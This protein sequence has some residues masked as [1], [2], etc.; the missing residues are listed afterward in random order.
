MQSNLPYI[1]LFNK[2]RPKSFSSIIGQSI[3]IHIIS[4]AIKN[5]KLATLIILSGHYG[6]GKTTIARI[7]AR[8][9]NCKNL[10]DTE[11]CLKCDSC[12]SIDNFTNADVLEIDAASNNGV[13]N[14]K[15]IIES[16]RYVPI[17]SKY[18]IYIIDEVHMLSKS[19]FN[20]FLKTL[21]EAPLHAKF[22]MA[23]TDL[24]K[25]PRTIIS[26]AQCFNFNSVSVEEIQILLEKIAKAE[27]Y[28]YEK[29]ALFIIAKSAMGAVRD[30]IS[31]LEQASLLKNNNIL[32]SETKEMLGIIFDD[33]IIKVVIYILENDPKNALLN[34]KFL[35]NRGMGYTLFFNKCLEFLHSQIIK[36]MNHNED[37]KNVVCSV[38][39]EKIY[40]IWNNILSYMGLIKFT[41]NKFQ[42]IEMLIVKLCY[43]C[44]LPSPNEIISKLSVSGIAD[45][46]NIGIRV[47]S[48]QNFGEIKE[49]LCNN[50]SDNSNTNKDNSDLDINSNKK[51]SKFSGDIIDSIRKEFIEVNFKELGD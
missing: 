13:D 18:K 27:K 1:S 47:Q 3:I 37:Q 41:S 21:E 36:Q 49:V 9:L 46:P 14:I 4:N 5:N 26:R 34:F 50:Q 48:M 11:P 16:A 6:V 2:Y 29:E 15:E 19:A 10:N 31:M 17:I 32:V 45:S 30:A 42:A 38:Q 7:I 33:E 12:V 40:R 44:H 35:Y 20:A 51:S 24:N 25:V 8:T 22:I 28:Q 43:I 39:I 23:T